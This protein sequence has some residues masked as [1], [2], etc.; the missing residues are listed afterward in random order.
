MKGEE[1][2]MIVLG[3]SARW[4]LSECVTR[5][6][7]IRPPKQTAIFIRDTVACLSQKEKNSFLVHVSK[8]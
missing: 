5:R 2:N 6:E 1:R 7:W 3:E 4:E 8:W